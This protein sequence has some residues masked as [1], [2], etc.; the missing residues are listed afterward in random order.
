MQRNL[1]R[2]YQILK[3][4]DNKKTIIEHFGYLKIIRQEEINRDNVSPHNY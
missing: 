2:A 3:I 4:L 1:T